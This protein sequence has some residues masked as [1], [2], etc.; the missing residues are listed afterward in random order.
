[1]E[2]LPRQRERDVFKNVLKA[3]AVPVAVG[4]IGLLLWRLG[5]MQ[6]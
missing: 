3:V 4:L 2:E 6:R 5:L 1:M